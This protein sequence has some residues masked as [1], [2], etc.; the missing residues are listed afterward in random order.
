MLLLLLLG[1][2]YQFVMDEFVTFDF[3]FAAE[4]VCILQDPD[5]VY[6]HSPF[7]HVAV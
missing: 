4:Q 7:V 1:H 5:P 6:V 2:T 3:M